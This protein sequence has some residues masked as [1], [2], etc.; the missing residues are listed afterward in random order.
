MSIPNNLPWSKGK[1]TDVSKFSTKGN[2]I[3]T[4]W[5]H[6]VL[7]CGKPDLVGITILS[8]LLFLHR[9][10]GELESSHGYGYFERKFNLTRAQM[11]DA[12]LRLHN[13]GLVTRSFRAVLVQGRKFPNEL[14]L[15]LN[16]EQLLK[17]VPEEGNSASDNIR[18]EGGQSAVN[19]PV[20]EEREDFCHKVLPNSSFTSLVNSQDNIREQIYIKSRSNASLKSN[21][22]ETNF[23]NNSDTIGSFSSELLDL[24]NSSDFAAR[25]HY[26]HSP[27]TNKK[28]L[29]AF[30]PL[31]EQD[32]LWLQHES[33]RE[34]SLNFI[35]QLILRLSSK[36][37]DHTFFGKKSV[38]RYMAKALASEM[39]DAAVVSNEA[40]RFGR[41]TSDFSGKI[42]SYLAEVEGSREV[43]P[44]AQ[45]RRKIAATLDS[46]AAYELLVTLKGVV[47]S[48]DGTCQLNLR[49]ACEITA[50]QRGVLLSQVR[51]VFGSY[52]T[53]LEF[54]VTDVW[55][56]RQVKTEGMAG[57]PEIDN[58]SLWGRVR[59]C[60]MNYFGKDGQSMDRN[61]FAKLAA[62][63]DGEGKKLV[64]KAPTGFMESY[65]SQHYRYL[66]ERF[67][68]QE[69]YELAALVVG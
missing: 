18:E 42:E 63:E 59:S 28:P 4:Y 65:I 33:G 64:L 41:S 22:L 56:Q 5:Y 16:L 67:C 69:S 20:H 49:T 51:G 39:R 66:I 50:Y 21:F 36:Y 7:S 62:E 17:L 2:I 27:L 46:R 3:P 53:G 14:H 24:T 34:F 26:H 23:K 31:D 30:H 55:Q 9:I 68:Q 10:T 1:T 8:E 61:W 47:V 52:V 48:A 38:L 13:C 19:F 15:K 35:N 60:L 45:L 44:E 32:A 25:P 11:Q 29:E 43:S 6:R 58:R 57:E 40:F 12:T 54:K 37:K